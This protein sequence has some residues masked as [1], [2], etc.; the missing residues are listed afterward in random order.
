M[1][2]SPGVLHTVMTL[3]YDVMSM[4]MSLASLEPVSSGGYYRSTRD[5]TES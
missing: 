1:S 2:K 4:V 3:A 5:G